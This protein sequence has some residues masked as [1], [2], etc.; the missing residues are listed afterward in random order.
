V[1]DV[2]ELPPLG[3]PVSRLG[4]GGW[5]LAG[6]F[7]AID[8]RTAVRSVL[9]YLEEGGNLIDTARAYGESE[10]RVGQA[11]REWTGEAP[12][13]ATKILSQGPREGWGR[14]LPVDTVF[15]RGSIRR[16][17]EESLRELGRER[18]DL[19]QLHLYWP[20]WGVDGYWLDELRELQRS[21][22]VL[23]IGVSLP[24]YRHDVAL[25]LVVSGAVNSVQTVV[26]IF[27][28]RA[29]D[30]L[31]PCAASNNVALIARGV[32]DESGLTGC[33][34]ETTEFAVDDFRREFFTASSRRE[35]VERIDELRH[36]VPGTA[37]SLAALAIGF[38]LSQPRV[39]SAI[40]SM[41]T[42]DLVRR[43][44]A[45]LHEEPLPHEVLDILGTRHRWTRN[46]FERL[47]WEDD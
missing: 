16:S 21:G 5:G 44:M 42:E 3:R 35:Y 23:R 20:T 7:G 33:V 45:L 32:L 40:V 29:L 12:V 24:D 34:E 19:V 8:R 17:L 31:A 6:A 14:P 4:Y 43:N 18:V 2:P 22:R 13:L 26:N 27:D 11:L 47:Y 9:T 46:F 30:C 28:P 25:E 39:T 1:T 38:V 36:W 41:Q 15:P 10:A 37:P